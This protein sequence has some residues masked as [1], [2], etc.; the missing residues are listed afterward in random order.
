MKAVIAPHP[1]S[2]TVTAPPSKSAGH[3]S[4]ICAALSDRPVTVHNCGESDDMTAT[5]NTLRALG[6]DITRNGLEVYVNPCKKNN[7]NVEIDCNES[8]STARFMI[9][10][11]CAL[12]AE[13][14]TFTGHGRL[15]ERPFDT[16][17]EVLRQNGITCSDSKLPM[18]V[19][20][21]LKSGEFSLPGNIS[22]QYISG[23]LL[24]LSIVE[25]DSKITLTS[26]LLSRDYVMMTVNELRFFGAEITVGDDF[27]KIKGRKTLTACDRTVE[28]D[29][30]QAA[31]HLS[32][33]AIGGDI[34][35]KGLDQNTLQGDSAMVDLLRQ[36]G[37][38][39]HIENDSVQVK[40]APLHGITIDASQ[41]PDL[42]PILAVT[43]AFADGTTTI[44]N[45]ER[46]R[47]KESDRLLETAVRLR[48]FGIDV[49]ETQDG[50]IIK[51]GK[52]Q[53]AD[54]TSANDHRIV[55]A[56]SV[57]AAYSSNASTIDGCQAINKSYP[58]FF[59][60][61]SSLGGE[62]NV[63]GNRL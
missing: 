38:T 57:M 43:A 7:R 63:I 62:C 33:G 8:G 11:A 36:F 24:A 39:I 23:L 9:P 17:V 12:G 47:I 61:F 32:A 15:P 49:T 45:A 16:I 10:V 58:L 30:S 55:M 28:G 1:L 14:I 35:V 3:R 22:S 44:T 2:G 54:I 25:G 40:S 41:I 5:I 18:T 27:F 53:G 56:F 29:W 60:D 4:L 51:G 6:A 46:L 21:Q 50:L 19:S 34:T 13:N 31:F 26:E 48:A 59:N 37:A 20:G 52:P 42:V